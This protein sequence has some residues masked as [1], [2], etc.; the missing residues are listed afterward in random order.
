MSLT[1]PE[2]LHLFS[3]VILFLCLF[4]WCLLLL[5]FSTMTSDRGM[6]NNHFQSWWAGWSQGLDYREHGWLNDKI[7]NERLALRAAFHGFSACGC[8]AA[9]TC[10]N[11]GRMMIEMGQGVLG[12]SQWFLGLKPGRWFQGPCSLPALLGMVGKCG[13]GWQ[14]D[15]GFCA[16]P[17]VTGGNRDSGTYG[18]WWAQAIHV[19]D[20]FVLGAGNQVPVTKHLNIHGFRVLAL[21]A[22]LT[23]KQM[24]N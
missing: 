21:F 14:R 12:G 8:M 15:L 13:F 20:S 1:L 23:W 22:Q 11:L 24:H 17:C 10:W 3:G 5:S 6:S 19:Q 9:C 7:L 16:V 4:L 18:S 2:S